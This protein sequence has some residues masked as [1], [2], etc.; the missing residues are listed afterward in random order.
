MRRMA[1]YKCRNLGYLV[2]WF[3]GDINGGAIGIG[4]RSS[5]NPRAFESPRAY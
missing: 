3:Q 5:F 2:G 1:D 4:K